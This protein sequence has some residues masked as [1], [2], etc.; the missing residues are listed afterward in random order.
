MLK[1]E[2]YTRALEVLSQKDDSDDGDSPFAGITAATSDS[3]GDWVVRSKVSTY[4]SFHWLSVVQSC[5]LTYSST[6][7]QLVNNNSECPWLAEYV[8]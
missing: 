6:Y 8:E 1:I 7:Q 3:S 4:L 2:R 5:F